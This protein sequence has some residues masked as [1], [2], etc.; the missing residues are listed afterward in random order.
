MFVP[1]NVMV[2]VWASVTPPVP[3]TVLPKVTALVRL[4]WMLPLSTMAPET[5]PVV[6]PPVVPMARVPPILTLTVPV[7][8]AEPEELAA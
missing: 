5:D 7:P 2:P 6:L 3:E 8:V 1:E 4:N